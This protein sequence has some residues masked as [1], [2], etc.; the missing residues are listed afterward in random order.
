M[1]NGNQYVRIYQ[2]THV[3]E[4][5][6][7]N[8]PDTGS[9]K[10]STNR[11]LCF[12]AVYKGQDMTFLFMSETIWSSGTGVVPTA[13]DRRVADQMG[14]KWTQFARDGQV[15]NWQPSNSQ[16]YN[17]SV[18]KGQDMTFLFMSETVWSSGTGAVPTADDRRVAD[19]MGEKWTQFARDGQSAA[20]LVVIPAV[21]HLFVRDYRQVNNW[22]PSN[23]QDYNYCNL[24]PQ[25]S[26]QTGYAAQARNVFNNQVDPIVKQAQTAPM[27]DAPPLQTQQSYAPSPA[28]TPGP[29]MNV[30]YSSNGPQSSAYQITYQVKNVP[31]K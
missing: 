2:F 14:E 15:N 19:Q 1:Q 29:A 12:T 28:F 30:Q 16:D 5:G 27:Y 24:N 6:R 20:R 9:W 26:I 17:Y 31:G 21:S 23:S 11:H 3:T 13:D 7:Q 22:Q 8:V 10:P 25:P 4:L 18:Y